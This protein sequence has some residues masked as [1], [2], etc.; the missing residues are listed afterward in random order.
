MCMCIRI[1]TH[2]RAMYLHVYYYYYYHYHIYTRARA[3]AYCTEVRVGC[4]RPFCCRPQHN[5]PN[6]NFEDMK[7]ILPPFPPTNEQQ[8][9]FDD[10]SRKV[11]VHRNISVACI[12]YVR[13]SCAFEDSLSLDTHARDGILIFC[14][15]QS[16]TR[17]TSGTTRIGFRGRLWIWKI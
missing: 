6:W 12:K 4:R 13:T 2:V 8:R 1:R 5:T 11:H 10:S 14:S 15:D 3:R 7:D 16:S 9:V 17:T